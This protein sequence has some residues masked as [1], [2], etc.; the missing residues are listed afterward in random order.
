MYPSLKNNVEMGTFSYVGEDKTY[1]Y[2]KNAEGRG[3][4]LG[5]KVWEALLNANGTA[6]LDLPDGGKELLPKLEQCGLVRT[7][8][9]VEDDGLFNRYILFAFSKKAKEKTTIFLKVLDLV[10]SFLAFLAFTAGAV[11]I[12][13]KGRAGDDLTNLFLYILL[14][15]ISVIS[16]EAGHALT[17]LAYGYRI[18]EAGILFVKRIPYGAYVSFDEKEDETRWEKFRLCMAG[19]EQ[20]LLFAGI[21][22][23]L[24]TFQG[25]LSAVFFEIAYINFLIAVCNLFP[26]AGLDGETVLSAICGVD[27]IQ[28]LAREKLF[29]ARERRKLLHSGLLGICVFL[30]F[31]AVLL[32]RV[33]FFLFLVTVTVLRVMNVF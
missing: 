13:T 33:V 24:A 5:R 15:I 3:F 16:H 32:S 1:Y 29:S 31:G 21:F 26:M 18:R 2:A 27:S 7:S 23:I 12:T 30:F 28:K 4:L 11:F 10:F 14:V 22:G 6:P 17:G 19:I 9:F 20:N 25:D 8:R